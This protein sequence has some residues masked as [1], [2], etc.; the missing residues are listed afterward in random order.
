MVSLIQVISFMITK[1]WGTSKR[2]LR[3]RFSG[4]GKPS[5]GTGC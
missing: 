1:A 2:C 5:A 4:G 3:C